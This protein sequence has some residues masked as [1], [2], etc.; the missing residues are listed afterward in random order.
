MGVFAAFLIIGFFVLINGCTNSIT[1]MLN[2]LTPIFGGTQCDW[3][4]ATNALLKNIMSL[5][6]A[7]N[8]MSTFSSL[9]NP[10]FLSK[11]LTDV[12]VAAFHSEA[13]TEQVKT[14]IMSYVLQMGIYFILFIVLAIIGLV[15]CFIITRMI[16]RHEVSS[17][18]GNVARFILRLILDIIVFGGLV[19]LLVY[20]SFNYKELPLWELILIIIGGLIAYALLTLLK[21]YLVFGT[22]KHMRVPFTK[23]V[24]PWKALLLYVADIIPIV[25]AA[26]VIVLL[27]F[28][29]NTIMAIIFG[30]PLA[31]LALIDM[32][33][34]ADS[35]V[36]ELADK[37]KAIY[38][39]QKQEEKQIKKEQKKMEKEAKKA[40]KN[41]ADEV[42][43]VE[44]EIKDEPKE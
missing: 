18:G 19:V 21:S 28:F 6:W 17:V 29:A 3:G 32:D 23:V 42:E 26:G 5:D 38:K 10:E 43:M 15:A 11:T 4:A 34:N 8:P 22:K 2:E 31:A 25:L 37:N 13:I 44:E 16:I 35:Y 20:L 39:A 30:I 1:S 24:N 27:Y 12:A 7:T 40:S 9:F 36:K 14:I 33:V 41:P